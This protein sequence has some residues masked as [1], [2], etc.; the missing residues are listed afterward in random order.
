MKINLMPVELAN[1][2][3]A[4][5]KLPTEDGKNMLPLNIESVKILI[6]RAV[7]EDRASTTDFEAIAKK[8]YDDAD[9]LG[10]D[11]P[12][13]RALTMESARRMT[14]MALRYAQNLGARFEQAGPSET[15]YAEAVQ[16]AVEAFC[17]ALKDKGLWK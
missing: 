9:E 1:K 13:G 2:V 4:D 11:G 5:A 16:N 7:T 10:H 14:I 12:L 8:L 17:T 6:A 15:D 3:V